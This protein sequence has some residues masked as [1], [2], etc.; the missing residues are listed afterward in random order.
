MS[1]RVAEQGRR[2]EDGDRRERHDDV[3]RMFVSLAGEPER[4]RLAGEVVGHQRDA[5]GLEGDSLPARPHRD[6]D[7][8]GRERGASLTP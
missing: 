2:N 1:K 3:W 6:S 8:G 7:L 5:G 4:G